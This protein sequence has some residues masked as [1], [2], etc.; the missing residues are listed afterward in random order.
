MRIRLHVANQPDGLGTD[1]T[2][3]YLEESPVPGLAIAQGCRI[4]DD[5]LVGD[6]SARLWRAFRRIRLAVAAAGHGDLE[7]YLQVT[8]GEY[9]LDADAVD[10]RDA[11]L[12]AARQVLDEHFGSSPLVVTAGDPERTAPYPAWPDQIPR[13]AIHDYYPR[14]SRAAERA[15]AEALAAGWRW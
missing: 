6:S 13:G 3:G 10:I 2:Y 7:A 14:E 1:M 11:M 9:R 5:V 12:P 8:D 15:V 4:I